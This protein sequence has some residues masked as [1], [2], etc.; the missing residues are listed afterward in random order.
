MNN[1]KQLGMTLVEVMVTLAVIAILSALAAPSVSDMLVS[2]RL[3]ALNN[4][5][6]SAFNYARGEA[7]KRAYEV[8][9]CVRNSDGS[10]CSADANADY[11]GGWLI[12]VDCSGDGAI[13]TANACDYKNAAGADMPDG[14]AESPEEILLDTVPSIGGVTITA[15]ATVMPKLNYKPNGNTAGAGGTITLNYNAQP[16]YKITIAPVTGRVSSCK[17]GTSGC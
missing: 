9:M 6:V 14:I 2:N 4:Q 3:N 8:G 16:Y 17:V 15:D 10:A 5:L 1:S 13:T 12:F 11:A 7:V